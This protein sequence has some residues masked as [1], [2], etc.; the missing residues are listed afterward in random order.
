MIGGGRVACRMI[1]PPIPQSPHTESPFLG[2]DTQPS[3][4]EIPVPAFVNIAG[5]TFGRLT[6]LL[7]EKSPRGRIWTC[8]C[9]CG[10]YTKTLSE[11]L[12]SGRTLSCGCL[13]SE[14][15]VSRNFKHGLSDT[16][17]RLVW[18]KMRQRCSNPDDI[19]F[20][21]YGA[22]GIAVCDQWQSFQEFYND[23]GKRPSPKH[24]LERI[25]N[26]G[27]YEPGNCRWATRK[28]Q[29]RNTRRNIFVTF[30]GER[31]VLADAIARSGISRWTARMMVKKGIRLEDIQ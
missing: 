5:Q 22:R 3:K 31:M 20:K 28:E 6:A 1:G 9:T 16:P 15:A 14:M 23:M 27:N 17:E 29:S 30:K 18:S 19:A 8:Q 10:N 25:N 12:R 11:R 26:D 13:R 24:T 4:S 21:S 7:S 2:C